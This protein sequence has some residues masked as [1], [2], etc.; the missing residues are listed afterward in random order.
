MKLAVVLPSRGLVFS[1]TVEELYRELHDVCEFLGDHYDVFYSHGRPIPECFNIPTEEALKGKYDY[2]LFVEE[3]MVLPEG[4]LRKMLDKCAPAVACDYPV[5]GGK[6]GT[7]MYDNEGQALFTGCGL[8][9]VSTDL[10]KS[11]PKPIWRTD[12]QWKPH[13]DDGKINFE[14]SLNNDKHYG[15][16]DVAFGLRLYANG[17]PIVV[18]EETIG[19]RQLVKRGEKGANDGFHEVLDRME[20]VKRTELEKVPARSEFEDIMI[21]EKV[22]K[23]KKDHFSKLADTKAPDYLRSLNAVFINHEVIKDWLYI[24]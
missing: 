2:V 13:M 6:G 18:M 22:V 9:L 14:I 11:L 16:R 24:K 4:I 17:T 12:I 23:V 10:L 19:Q 1:K 8:L 15:Q 21:G 7:V 5:S 3:D 20:I